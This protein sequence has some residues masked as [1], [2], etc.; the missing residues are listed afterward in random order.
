MTA[1]NWITVLLLVHLQAGGIHALGIVK[2]GG[3]LTL[4]QQ[5]HSSVIGFRTS[6]YRLCWLVLGKQQVL[7]AD[8]LRLPFSDSRPSS[9]SNGRRPSL[10]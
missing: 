10:R 2:P 8:T 9:M 3:S 4:S 7:L 5:V 6:V 1:G